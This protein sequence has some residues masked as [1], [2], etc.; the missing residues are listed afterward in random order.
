ME[1]NEAIK[2]RKKLKKFATKYVDRLGDKYPEKKQSGHNISHL[3]QV[4]RTA[5]GTLLL[6]VNDNT[7]FCFF[8]LGAKLTRNQCLVASRGECVVMLSFA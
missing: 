3:L 4:V 5:M 1:Q 7:S 8:A 6:R 2:S